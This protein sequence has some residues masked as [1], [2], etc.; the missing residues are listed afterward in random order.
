M[1]RRQIVLL[2]LAT[3]LFSGSVLVGQ[4]SPRATVHGK[5]LYE[6]ETYPLVE[7]SLARMWAAADAVAEVKIE[8]SQVKGVGPLP[9]VRTFHTCRVQRVL[10]GDITKGASFVFTED[11][12][13]LELP[14][15]V[16]RAGNAEPLASG[17]RYVVFLLRNAVA[18]TWVLQG[19][20]AGAFK[21]REG[22]VEPQGTG[23]VAEEQRNL[24]ERQFFDELE[25]LAGRS[26]PKA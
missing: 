13:D 22:R 2:S 1:T 12:G 14:D 6:Q 11:A 3:S 24:R 18:G 25:R 17:S 23:V 20:Q 21:L 16:L 26:R 4:A 9:I 19:Q 7:R 5:P 10:K 15:R 8:S